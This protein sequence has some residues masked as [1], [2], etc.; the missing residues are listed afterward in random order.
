MNETRSYFAGKS[1]LVATRHGKEKVLGPLFSEKLGVH[2][3]EVPPID[4]DRLGTFSGETER[5]GDMLETAELKAALGY[6]ACAADLVLVSEGSFGP[7]PAIPFVASDLELLYLIESETGRFWRTD[8]LSTDTNFA[9]RTIENLR[10]LR[11]FAGEVGFPEHAIILK[12]GQHDFSALFK[13]LQTHYDLEKAA[14][15]L[16]ADF[17]SVW[18]ETDMRA[19]L[20]PTRMN[21]L[22]KAAAKMIVRLEA[23]CPHCQLPGFAGGSLV[24]GLP[25]AWC[26]RPSRLPLYEQ[27]ICSFCGHS[28]KHMHPQG[29]MAD[30][31]NCDYCN[32]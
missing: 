15:S 28:E 3:L 1:L 11:E 30:P 14:K 25:C 20:N 8:Y 2:C 9:A 16:W 18:A 12:A 17:G 4:T 13:G 21:V 6:E 19:H 24:A 22:A 32:P 31:A 27:T 29:A 26:Q 7:H 23:A 5:P 10:D